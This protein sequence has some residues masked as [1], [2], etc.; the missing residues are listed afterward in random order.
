[1]ARLPEL[2]TLTLMLTPVTAYEDGDEGC[3]VVGLELD[4]AI[5]AHV[6]ERIGAL[7]GDVRLREALEELLSG[8]DFDS[9]LLE[10]VLLSDDSVPPTAWKVGEALGQCF[11]EDARDCLFP[12][13]VSFDLRN[14]NASPAGTDLV[15]FTQDEGGDRFAFGEVKTSGDPALPPRVVTRPGDG[16]QDQLT[17]LCGG[18]DTRTAL[19]LYLAPRALGSKWAEKF[20]SAASR[21]FKEQGDVAIFGV[22][23]RTTPPNLRDLEGCAQRLLPY[24]APEMNLELVGLYVSSAQ[25]DSLRMSA[26]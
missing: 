7:L 14:P 15:G 25:L 4:D 6:G 16:L 9:T 18:A 3:R 5:D 2:R 21:F 22:L 12:W 10:K 13:P 1:M 11:L 23:V 26:A 24:R 20:K 8:S 19:V 17:T